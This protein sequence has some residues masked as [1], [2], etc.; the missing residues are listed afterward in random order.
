VNVDGNDVEAIFE[1]AHDA[2]EHARDGAGPTLIEC[3]T[4]RMHGHGAHDDMGYV[5]DGML[6]EWERRDPIDRYAARLVAELGFAEEEVEEIREQVR[7]FVADC[8]EKALASPMPDPT[9][10]TAGVFAEEWEP[11]G[12]GEAPWSRWEE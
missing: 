6:E 9:A 12:D 5:P 8:A 7:S 1:A 10:A 3:Q 2:V 4:M 11:L